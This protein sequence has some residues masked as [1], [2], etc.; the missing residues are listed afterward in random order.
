MLKVGKTAK[1]PL[2]IC[3][4][5][6]QERIELAKQYNEKLFNSIVKALKANGWT[7]MCS[8]RNLKTCIMGKPTLP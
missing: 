1:L 6:A 3:K 5:S 7:K 8:L 4:G 2:K